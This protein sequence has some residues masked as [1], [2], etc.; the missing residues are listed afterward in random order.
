ME[1]KIRIFISYSLPKRNTQLTIS[2]KRCKELAKTTQK[3]IKKAE[4]DF[5]EIYK[6]FKKMEDE[7]EVLFSE[8]LP[9]GAEFSEVI[10]SFIAY[11]HVFVP[12]I[13]KASQLSGWVQQEIGYAMALN[14]PVLPIS[15]EEI[16]PGGMISRIQAFPWNKGKSFTVQR[17]RDMLH[18]TNMM[19][20]PYNLAVHRDDRFEFIRDFEMQI[21]SLSLDKDVYGHIRNKGSLSVFGIPNKS[22]FLNIWD[23]LYGPQAA[24]KRKLQG[25]KERQ[26][27]E[28]HARKAGFS[29]IIN[30]NIRFTDRDKVAVKLRIKTLLKFLED[31]QKTNREAAKDK[32]IKVVIALD[33]N[34]PKREHLTILGDYFYGET[35]SAQKGAGLRNTLFTRNAPS[36]AAKIEEFDEELRS[37]L[38]VSEKDSLDY[39]I[40][41]LK[42]KLKKIQK[43]EKSRKNK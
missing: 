27:L 14:I 29:L 35:L 42:K 20:D 25:R 10:K 12:I 21:Q 24:D 5:K 34:L 26:I 3:E 39:A 38:K 28:K 15:L 31:I 41:R 30:P 9:F 1:T 13:S 33:K 17:F 32:K 40:R 23:G 22:E 36:V 8:T 43:S 18:R 4:K 16:E 7:V 2:K 6:H 19:K 37:K 11:S